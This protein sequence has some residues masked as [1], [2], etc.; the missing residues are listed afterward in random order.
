VFFAG[1]K[2]TGFAK[3]LPELR[4]QSAKHEATVWAAFK[5]DLAV[6]TLEKTNDFRFTMLEVGMVVLGVQEFALT[7]HPQWRVL[8]AHLTGKLRGCNTTAEIKPR[9][10]TRRR[11]EQRRSDGKNMLRLLQT[12]FPLHRNF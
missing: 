10:L 12:T 11:R 6:H 1:S 7:N 8:L 4:K 5:R 3:A 2:T 9:R